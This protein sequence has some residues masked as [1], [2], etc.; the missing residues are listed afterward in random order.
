MQKTFKAAILFKQNSPLKVIDLEIPK[1]LSRGQVLVK[2]VSAAIC[3][4]QLGEIKGVKGKDKWLPHCMGHEGYGTVIAKHKSVKKLKIND[5]VIMHW[6]KGFG[7]NS[8]SPSYSSE[9]HNIN[10]GLVTTFQEYSVVSENR[11]TKIKKFKSSHIAI[12]PLLGCAIP[13][14]WGILT[15]E[16]FINKQDSVLIFGAG[17]LG[18]TLAIVAKILGTKDILL[19]D[20][21]EKKKKLKEM[22]INFLNINKIGRLDKKKF[23]KIIDTTGN[24]KIISNAFDRVKKNGKLILIAQPKINS[25]LKIKDPL[26]LFNAPSDNIKIIISDGGLFEPH[27]EMKKIYNLVISNISKFAKIISHEVALK[28]INKGINLISRGKA[29]RVAIKF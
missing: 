26:K 13:T 10:A 24:V 19:V 25:L 8:N 9:N 16:A 29:I 3:G 15:K 14:A 23:D 2:I 4:A 7:I 21:Y 12:A 1:K 11:V 27:L 17:G 18:V 28:N 22:N 20:K 6:R 5:Y